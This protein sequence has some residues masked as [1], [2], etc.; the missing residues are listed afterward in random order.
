MAQLDTPSLEKPNPSGQTELEPMAGPGLPT[1]E[2]LPHADV[3][4]YDGQCVFCENQVGNLLRFDGRDRLA[5]VSLHHPFVAEHF[6]DLSHDDLMKQI[7]LIPASEPGYSKTRLG[8]AEA[9]R[10]LSRRL[11]R[12][13]LLAPLMHVPFTMPLMQWCY[14]MIAKR[15]YKIAGKRGELNC[16]DDGTCQL[17]FGEDQ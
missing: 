15:R 6:P 2:D 16:D 11:P 10:Y 3:V 7:Y 13:W 14:H 8:G 4:I 9:I 5:F 17:H 12:L 1:P